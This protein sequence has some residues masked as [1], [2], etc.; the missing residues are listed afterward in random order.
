[1]AA[2]Y[3]AG[4]SLP[5]EWIDEWRLA[6]APY[7]EECARPLLDLGSG[8]GLWLQALAGWFDVTIVAAEPSEAMRRNAS[9]KRL[10]AVVALVG[11]TA[12]RIPL[13]PGSCGCAWLST[14]LHHIADLEAC[15]G[16]LRRVLGGRGTVLIRNSFGDRLDDI[17]WLRFW[18]AAEALAAERWPTVDA[19]AQAFSAGGF[20]VEALVSVPEVIARDLHSYYDRLRLR[21]NS[22]LTLISDEDFAEGLARLKRAADRQPDPE[23]VVDHRD[24]LVLR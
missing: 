8:T 14:V 5:L 9:R 18:P 12:E 23:P 3:D 20:E 19:T 17:N 13:K 21:A 11:G 16:E 4:R 24:L 15:A 22:T 10:P 6:L 1:M 2:R 7:L